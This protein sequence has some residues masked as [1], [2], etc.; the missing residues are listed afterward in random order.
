MKTKILI[1]TILAILISI[2]F[3]Y[4][5]NIIWGDDT[6]T[7][8]EIT[9]SNPIC[10]NHNTWVIWQDNQKVSNS[11]LEDCFREDGFPSTTCC[12]ENRECILDIESVN[13][14]RCQG[15]PAP[16]FCFDYDLERYDGDVLQAEAH[17]EGFAP[18]VAKRSAEMTNGPGFCDN[19]KESKY[20]DG[21]TCWR[22]ISNCRCVW[23]NIKEACDH[24]WTE[25]NWTCTGDE[26]TTEL[27]DCTFTKT[28]ETNCTSGFKFIEWDGL[29]TGDQPEECSDDDSNPDNDCECKDGSGQ[30]RCLSSELSF[31]GITGIIVL[32]I[33][34]VIFYILYSKKARKKKKR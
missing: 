26:I 20:I 22:I 1:L 13:L 14:G 11:S 16:Q 24:R 28:G 33:I 19:S 6:P 5:I 34:I 17:C 23:D 2:N 3:V 25:S 27:G 21:K 29:W 15:L 8:F 32:I 9:A 4:A 31:F 7:S 12:P 30:V 10:K 18:E